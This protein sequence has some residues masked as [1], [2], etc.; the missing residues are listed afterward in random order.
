MALI[1][2]VPVVENGVQI[3]ATDFSEFAVG[4]G[5]PSGITQFGLGS[6]APTTMAIEND[7]VEGNFFSMVGQGVQAWAFGYDAFFGKIDT[8]EILA[9][10]F[11]NYNLNTRKNIGG[12]ASISGLIAQPEPNPDMDFWGGNLFLTPDTPDTETTGVTSDDGSGAGPLSLAKIQE[13]FQNQVWAWIRIR[14][15]PNGG[16]P[17]RDDWTGT[18]W[19]GDLDDEPTSPDGTS[20]NIIRQISG[21]AAVGWGVSQ[22]GD[23]NK[24]QIAFLSYSGDPTVEAPPVPNDIGTVW[25]ACSVDPATVWAVCN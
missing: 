21:F 7:A 2:G 12:C 5:V 22:F 1:S 3:G 23:A 20:T 13:P 9:R 8:G 24:Q 14:R 18:T 16:D 10:F 17:S 19:Y 25:S 15:V 11:S 6:D 4:S